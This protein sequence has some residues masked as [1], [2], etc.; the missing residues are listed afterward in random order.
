MRQIELQPL[1]D[2]AKGLFVICNQLC[3]GDECKNQN[4][5]CNSNIQLNI[6][7]LQH[8]LDSVFSI[9][10]S[11]RK[12]KRG[13]N[14]VGSGLKWLFGTMDHDDK[15]KIQGVIKTLGHRQDQLHSLIGNSVHLM[16]NYSAQW[17]LT[18]KNQLIQESNLLSL[19]RELEKRKNSEIKNSD[20]EKLKTH[21]DNLCLA[22]EIQIEKLKT[23]ILFLKTGILDPYLMDPQELI[24]TFSRSQIG[25]VIDFPDLDALFNQVKPFALF[26]FEKKIIIHVGIHIPVANGDEYNL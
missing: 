19:Q 2:D 20:R 15:V 7:K 6:L 11:Y 4:H 23:A 3:V 22:I 18:Q 13:L 16:K 8:D 1:I 24:G 17:E 14:F 12:S 5:T 25:Y 10:G 26:D 9:M 21:F